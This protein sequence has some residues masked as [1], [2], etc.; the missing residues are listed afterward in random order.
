MAVDGISVGIGAV[1]ALLM[2]AGVKGDSV[3][4][5]LQAF[6][7]G[8]GPGAVTPTV[9]DVSSGATGAG[10]TGSGITGQEAT[11]AGPGEAA[12]FTAM[13]ASVGA[14]PTKAN[15]A[16]MEAWQQHESPWNAQP[17][18]G[19]LFTHNPL[20][21]TLETSASNGSVNSVGVQTYSS[22]EAGIVATAE[23]LLDGYPAI[24][25]A[26]RSGTGLSTGNAD[27]AAEL[28]KWSGGGYSSV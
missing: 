20:N 1:G 28:S 18:D 10:G 6:V 2:Y 4:A 21:T 26:L 12:W 14:L 13:L 3:P 23:T 8:Q 25:S 9:T 27:V 17:P 7:R 24:V 19:A 5:L 16:S 22:A 15:L 11:P